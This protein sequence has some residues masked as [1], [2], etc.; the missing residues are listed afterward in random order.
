M[1]IHPLLSLITIFLAISLCRS[2]NPITSMDS[3]L[4]VVPQA[5]NTA[6]LLKYEE[7]PV[8]KNSGVPQ[9]GVPI[10]TISIDGINIPVALS[11]NSSGIRV[12]EVAPWTGHGW[13]LIGG[14]S[15]TRTVRHLPD[16]NQ[17]GYMW[18]PITTSEIYDKCMNYNP[19]HPD[20]VLYTNTK[21]RDYTLDFEP[22]IFTYSVPGISGKFMFN[23]VHGINEPGQVKSFP[24]SNN[25]IVPT[26]N[27]QKN[28]IAWTI[29]DTQGNKFEFDIGNTL[30]SSKGYTIESI[31]NLPQDYPLEPINPNLDH[32][33]Q[34]WNLFK[35]TTYKGNVINFSYYDDS[36]NE[37]EECS[38][39]GQSRTM[40]DEM[41]NLRTT[42]MGI[43]GK[44]TELAGISGSFGSIIFNKGSQREDYPEGRTLSEIRVNAPGN[45]LRKKFALKYFYTKADNY[46]SSIIYGCGG[47][48]N[49]T[50]IW[51]T[52]YHPNNPTAYDPYMKHMFLDEIEI[53]DAQA[54][55][56]NTS[57]Y[58]FEYYDEHKLPH[59][60]S[61]AQDFWGYYNGANN[62]TLLLDY[63]AR[64]TN[65]PYRQ[66]EPE[67]AI[68]GLLK[69]MYYPTGGH[70]EFT[71]EGNW[72]TTVCGN[73]FGFR[74]IPSDEKVLNF[75]SRVDDY[76]IT[77][78]NDYELPS[79]CNQIYTFSKPLI[80]NK[81]TFMFNTEL[82]N[83][84]NQR[85]AHFEFAIEYSTSNGQPI[86]IV[87]EDNLPIV[88]ECSLWL[89][90]RKTT[91]DP[92][93]YDD[94]SQIDM[95]NLSF[96]TTFD[97]Y[98][99]CINTEATKGNSFPMGV[100]IFDFHIANSLHN[101]QGPVFD[102]VNDMASF[103]V[104]IRK[105]KEDI[106]F[107][108]DYQEVEIPVGGMRIKKIEDFTAENSIAKRREFKYVADDSIRTSGRILSTP[109]FISGNNNGIVESSLS[110]V[111]LITTN[112]GNVNYNRV[113]EDVV[114]YTSSSR[115][116]S[117]V[118]TFRFYPI[119]TPIYKN[120]MIPFIEDWR[121]GQEESTIVP[122]KKGIA[123]GFWDRFVEIDYQDP[124]TFHYALLPPTT[125][126][127]YTFTLEENISALMY[128]IN[129]GQYTGKM[130]YELQYGQLLQ[131]SEA[132]KTF[133]EDSQDDFIE[134][135]IHYNYNN[136]NY[137]QPSSIDTYLEDGKKLR[138]KFY[139]PYDLIGVEPFAQTLLSNNRFA[140]PMIEE[141][142]MV[143]GSQER[144]LSKSRTTYSASSGK[145]LPQTIL[146][147]KGDNDL[148]PRVVY[149]NYDAHGNPIDVSIVGG[150]HTTYIWGYGGQHLVAKI[151]KLSHSQLPSQLVSDIEGAT[152]EAT[153]LGYLQQLRNLT[154]VQ[155]SEVTTF[156]Y[157][158]L[159]G[160]STI[161][162]P[163]GYRM[164]YFY[165]DFGRLKYVKDMDGNVLSENQ[166][167]YK[168]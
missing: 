81:R 22:D 3:Y 27:A 44:Y 165:D 77:N 56:S 73:A 109:Y 48:I 108:N 16:D 166:Y 106:K 55:T 98:K 142:Y 91:L 164:N 13:S 1:K 69:K 21:I 35:I 26:F 136:D 82:V 5:P 156:T 102:I 83:G 139:Y 66:V 85:V 10:H 122:L 130:F 57:K 51:N 159:V 117:T 84:V 34:T 141:S 29:Y 101:P 116:L 75:N 163:R 42:Y 79:H 11:Y 39:S 132:T 96:D 148:E 58:T 146:M 19:P 64:Y 149:N 87:G 18:T 63:T 88:G 31:G 33:T 134:Q 121:Y 89:T 99:N 46:P 49:P 120:P 150:A 154:I 158:P 160:L 118:S 52:L 25:K 114:D 53:F 38:F 123:R 80:L 119:Y 92:E 137:G 113:S 28:I 78:Y 131:T 86:C 93:L 115:K 145:I 54:N 32:Y 20:C 138:Q 43:E 104:N 6:S 157:V 111:P 161:T 155:N 65:T 12:N 153:L 140:T 72:G 103:N 144:L 24:V 135:G 129:G 7:A 50:P 36:A 71:Y 94:E 112:S 47:E 151:E 60:N 68:T 67:Y 167:H 40:T 45:V 127:P 143:E 23:Q 162:D 105:A 76:E 9:I 133:I 124:S 14:G 97:L 128:V 2:Q 90:V 95:N 59:R 41:N 107:Y 168:N 110:V 74:L 147:A 152:N 126:L 62:S 17:Y 70:T 15:I 37:Y 125:S 30:T 4:P 100:Y 8:S 61:Y